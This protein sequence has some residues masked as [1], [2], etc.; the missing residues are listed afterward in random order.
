MALIKNIS[1]FLC[2]IPL[3]CLPATSQAQGDAKKA[4][5]EMK[6][7]KAVI[8]DVREKDELSSGWVK[9]AL[10]LPMSHTGKGEWLTNLKKISKDK[11]IYLYCRS[12]NRAGS[13]KS[14]LSK[15]GLAVENLGGFSELKAQDIPSQLDLPRCSLN[16]KSCL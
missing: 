15:K 1:K 16:E 10:W 9:N 11:K 13:L 12:G 2:S 3:L 6:S 7:G 14:I 5:A 8:I 4:F